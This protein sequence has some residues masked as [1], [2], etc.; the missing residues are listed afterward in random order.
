MSHCK[1]SEI[2]IDE[3]LVS[4]DR[5]QACPKKVAAI[6]RSISKSGQRHPI[7]VVKRSY[8]WGK[9]KY[10]LSAGLHRLQAAKALGLA[11]ISATLID[12]RASVAWSAAENLARNDLSALERADEI[13]KFAKVEMSDVVGATGGRQPYDK[14]ISRI[15]KELGYDRRIIRQ[16]YLFQHLEPL[17]RQ[18]LVERRLDRNARFIERVARLSGI[19]DQLAEVDARV[20]GD[21]FC[22]NGKKVR[23][24]DGISDKAD[25]SDNDDWLTDLTP[26]ETSIDPY[27][28]RLEHSWR[29]SSTQVLFRSAPTDSKRRFCKWLMQ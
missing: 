16:A 18:K 2:A 7:T 15:A 25:K 20:K 8:F 9:E 6:A 12:K 3:I 11:V 22:R 19:K 28:E 26:S 27:L 24:R 14:G 10:E 21:P 17:V 13:V 4:G 29:E 5:R 23:K 1:I